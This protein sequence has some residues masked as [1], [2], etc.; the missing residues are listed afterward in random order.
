[1]SLK[2][3]LI[4]NILLLMAASFLSAA[5]MPGVD[6]GAAILIDARSGK[7]LYEK[8]ASEAMQPASLTKM[9]TA[10]IVL[11]ELAAGGINWDERIKMT[12]YAFRIARNWS[13][14]NTPVI[15]KN[16]RYSI[17]E[18]LSA[19]LIFSSNSAA[20]TLAEHIAG[21]EVEFVKRM[22]E[23]ARELGLKKARFYDSTGLSNGKIKVK[24][25]YS[26]GGNRMS[27]RDTALLAWR[28]IK[29][30]PEVVEISSARDKEY[31]INGKKAFMLNSNWMIPG[32]RH[33]YKGLD[34]LKTGHTRSAGY[35][36][37]ATAEIGA[38]RLIS[39]VMKAR[40]RSS[41]FLQTRRIM[42]WGFDNHL[43]EERAPDGYRV[44]IPVDNN[45]V[46]QVP[47]V[48][49]K[50]LIEIV[51]RADAGEADIK[52]VLVNKDDDALIAPLCKNQVVGV[53]MSGINNKAG[54]EYISAVGRM[55]E[56][57]AIVLEKDVPKTGWFE[58]MFH[59]MKI[60]VFDWYG[61]M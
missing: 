30:F 53:L 15:M 32:L 6:A 45:I 12:R 34:G 17:R 29:D 14:S 43:M 55:I 9:M 22:N 25:P 4:S 38:M 44:L 33:G 60:F 50:P 61:I 49:V 26:D 57:A 18:L 5:V 41:C 28:L 35:C 16:Q 39:V 1:M 54:R 37:T 2:K 56:S 24:M 13:L 46:E 10:Y 58:L 21:S 40:T 3:I 36:F 20:I 23:K 59:H 48:T 52:Y 31:I 11:E 19:A 47:A 51:N 7:I 8:N 27:A 42:D